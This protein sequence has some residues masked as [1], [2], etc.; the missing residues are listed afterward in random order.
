MARAT[1][2]ATLQTVALYWHFVDFVWMFI[3]VCFTSYRIFWEGI[4][5]PMKPGLRHASTAAKT[6][7]RFRRI[8]LVVD[9][10][11]LSRH[12]DYVEGLYPSGRLRWTQVG[13]ERN[14]D[15]CNSDSASVR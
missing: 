5:D 2:T 10:A 6:L 13:S 9:L 15:L 12:S 3:V 11:R 1:L 14:G 7:V 4:M 8:G